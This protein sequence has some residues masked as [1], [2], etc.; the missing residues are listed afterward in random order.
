LKA[1]LLYKSN[2]ILGEGPS[3]H[4]QRKSFFWVDIEGKTVYEY[5]WQDK[6]THQWQLQHRVSLVME[7]NSDTMLLALQGGLAFLDLNTGKLDWLL[8]IEKEVSTNRTN[9]GACDTEGRLWIGTM[10]LE[11]K[12]G[13]GTLYCIDK[14]MQL[15]KKLEQLSIP[16]G[17]AWSLNND[18]IYHTDTATSTVRSY[19]FYPFT[20]NI[21]F[22]RAA[23]TVP[24]EMGSPD[25]M[26]M[27]EEGMLWIAHWGGFGV[28]RWNPENGMLLDKLELPVP[29]VTCCAFGGE[30]LDHL[31]ITT[32]KDGLSEEQLGKYPDSGNVFIAKPGVKGI[33]RN[34]FAVIK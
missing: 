29:Q 27:D 10:N 22:E 21:S 14:D 28:Y 20:G 32:A 30:N 34:K 33:A 3:W 26:C 5:N 19:F 12:E 23:I 13:Y 7:G 18:K 31:F 16:N 24:S 1:S 11:C 2:C 17:I 15:Q 6:K 25:G 4:S 9:D 8:D